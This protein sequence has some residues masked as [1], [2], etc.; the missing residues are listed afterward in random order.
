MG[1]APKFIMERAE[2]VMAMEF[3]M[4]AGE[5]AWEHLAPIVDCDEQGNVYLSPKT[6]KALR[7]TE[8]P[9]DFKKEVWA[10]S[11]KLNQS[12]ESRPA[13]ILK[14]NIR[15]IGLLEQ[16]MAAAKEREEKSFGDQLA[17][18]R[19]AEKEA[20]AEAELLRKKLHALEVQHAQRERDI[21]AAVEDMANSLKKEQ[22][23]RK[24]NEEA[25]NGIIKDLQKQVAAQKKSLEEAADL[26]DEQEKEKEM[27]KEEIDGLK[28]Q[29][30]EKKENSVSFDQYNRMEMRCADQK[31]R[32]S[33]L[34]AD[35]YSMEQEVEN[36]SATI[37]NLQKQL[38]ESEAAP[39][40]KFPKE[41]EDLL[42]EMSQHFANGEG[43]MGIRNFIE[44]AVKSD[45][46][47][48]G[49]PPE[50]VMTVKAAASKNKHTVAKFVAGLNDGVVHEL[51][52]GDDV[53]DLYKQIRQKDEEINDLRKKTQEDMAK[54]NAGNPPQAQQED[55]MSKQQ[56]SEAELAATKFAVENSVMMQAVVE[57]IV[58]DEKV[59][60][61]VS[62]ILDG[63]AQKMQSAFKADMEAFYE[64]QKQS[65]TFW[66][67]A[68]W[69]AIG[70]GAVV[71][72]LF[73][74]DVAF[75]IFK[76]RPLFVSASE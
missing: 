32:I 20:K 72:T 74:I 28:K 46:L 66:T 59:V 10:A 58:T 54:G 37:E 61:K 50:A 45:S 36:L 27:M 62:K 4:Q 51:L 21:Q 57:A 2:R 34:E 11:E 31:A 41:L 26:F 12:K 3:A 53:E 39:K 17:E 67:V 1:I 24:K 71:G 47:F 69:A 9:E 33:A 68:K 70:T 22:E 18:A 29:A 7:D 14:A 38:A 43:Q 25:A 40:P 56:V 35:S 16:Q 60:A 30:E 65:S 42:D 44:K 75:R 19:K 5:K 64:R 15:G 52:L 73:I 55:T 23:K 49:M 13:P 8:A 63:H 6:A 76:G 48:D